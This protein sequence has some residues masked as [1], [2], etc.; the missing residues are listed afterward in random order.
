MLTVNLLRLVNSAA[1]GLRVRTASVR[2]ALIRVG[3]RPLAAWL[4]L[5]VYG[6]NGSIETSA[7]FKTVVRKT[8][9]EQANESG[10]ATIVIA[11]SPDDRASAPR[12]TILLSTIPFTE[13][14]SVVMLRE[15]SQLV[16]I[17]GRALTL[18]VDQPETI[19]SMVRA[20]SALPGDA[21]ADCAVTMADLSIWW[22]NRGTSGSGGAAIGDFNGDRAVDRADLLVWVRH[23][24][25]RCP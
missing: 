16:D 4:Q 2:D 20:D 14:G 9:A 22:E 24:F 12:G 18:V 17:E 13:P 6:V 11:L 10:E 15:R 7:L 25:R 23:L 5:L 1:A 8:R 21:N 3:R 19:T